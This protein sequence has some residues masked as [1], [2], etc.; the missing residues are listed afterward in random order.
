MKILFV[1]QNRD[2]DIR[3]VKVKEN[4][5]TI[6]NFV[7]VLNNPHYFYFCVSFFNLFTLWKKKMLIYVEFSPMP[8]NTETFNYENVLNKQLINK[9]FKYKVWGELFSNQNLETVILIVIFLTAIVSF[10]MGH[11][12]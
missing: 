5:F 7:Y 1:K 11:F 8:I 4:Q 6:N 12:L 3:N 9:M 10:A 2:I